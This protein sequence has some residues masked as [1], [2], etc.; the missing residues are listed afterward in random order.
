MPSRPGCEAGVIKEVTAGR[1][2]IWERKKKKN[3]DQNENSQLAK[4]E[5]S[6][7]KR[8]SIWL[9]HTI[10]HSLENQ[11]WVWRS[12]TESCGEDG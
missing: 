11:S 9:M 2:G 12:L 5:K 7:H 3:R 8:I 10:L 6:T 1:P 4:E